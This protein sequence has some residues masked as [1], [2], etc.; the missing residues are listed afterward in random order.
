MKMTPTL[1]EDITRLSLKKTMIGFRGVALSEAK[2][3]RDLLKTGHLGAVILFDRDVLTGSTS[4]NIR[5]PQQLKRLC[6]EIK[7]CSGGQT[8]IAIDQEGGRVSRLPASSGFPTFPTAQRLGREGEAACEKAGK[9]CGEVLASLGITWNLAPVFGL[10]DECC[11]VLGGCE[12]C[13]SEHPEAVSRLAM[14]YA[15]GLSAGGVLNCAKHFPGHGRALGDT[16]KGF[17]DVEETYILE[18]RQAFE[19]AAKGQHLDAIMTAHL[20]H[21][22]WGKGLPATLSPVVNQDWIRQE[23]GF[24]GVVV[25]DDLQMGAIEKYASMEKTVVLATQAG[26]DML[27]MGNNLSYDEQ[28][29]L[30]ID[31]ILR[32][33]VEKGVLSMKLLRDSAER[34]DRLSQRF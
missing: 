2:W 23:L 9:H 7:N 33:A 21:S 12:R 16:H 6:E 32:E 13:F 19:L 34:I 3:L 17:V 4:R 26:V 31:T 24:K 25:S 22:A 14:A 18:E 10:H 27:I 20:L 28:G 8:L 29:W 5:D 30:K 15:K 11:P 1:K